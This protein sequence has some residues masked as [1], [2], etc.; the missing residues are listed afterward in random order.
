MNYLLYKSFCGQLKFILFISTLSTQFIVLK[1]VKTSFS[2]DFCWMRNWWSDSSKDAGSACQ[3]LRNKL[4][5]RSILEPGLSETCSWA[6]SISIF[7][8]YTWSSNSKCIYVSIQVLIEVLHHSILRSRLWS[9]SFCAH[10]IDAL[11][12]LSWAVP[13]EPSLFPCILL[14]CLDEGGIVEEKYS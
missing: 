6:C 3:R 7:M 10:G 8:L 4:Q 13:P 1:V 9:E 12:V 11:S 2:L 5:K 14:S